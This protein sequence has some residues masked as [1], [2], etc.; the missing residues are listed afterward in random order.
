MAMN[1]K[2]LGQ[3]LL[4]NRTRVRRAFPR[5]ALAEIEAAIKGAKLW[6]QIEEKEPGGF[7]DL[8]WKH[9]GGKPQVNRFTA[10][11]QVPAQTEMSQGLAKELKQR[12]KGRCLIS[13]CTAGGMGVVAILER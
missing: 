3:H 9:V 11:E 2:R 4:L 8:I 13:I 12:G 10:R 7:H 5:S 6:L 1:I